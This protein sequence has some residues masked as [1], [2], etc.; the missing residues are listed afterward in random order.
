VQLVRAPYEIGEEIRGMLLKI[1]YRYTQKWGRAL[2]TPPTLLTKKT[3]F[4]STNLL[5]LFSNN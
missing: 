5:I 1:F 3:N 2:R 4:Y